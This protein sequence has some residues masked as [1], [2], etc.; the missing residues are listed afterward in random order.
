MNLQCVPIISVGKP[1]IDYR[2]RLISR[3]G[4]LAGRNQTVTKNSIKG[5]EIGPVLAFSNGQ[6]G[7]TRMVAKP[8][9]T[10]KTA[11][12]LMR[13]HFAPRW[14]RDEVIDAIVMCSRDEAHAEKILRLSGK[15]G[16]VPT[17]EDIRHFAFTKEPFVSPDPHCPQCG[18]SGFITRQ[19]R[20]HDGA[21]MCSCLLGGR[22]GLFTA[23]FM[24]NSGGR[25]VG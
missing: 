13:K 9:L 22:K 4:K 12:R 18:G 19:V 25:R 6:E 2:K 16:R 20:G 14:N 23:G 10:R 7:E 1:G 5:A 15:L 8:A 21:E 11:A 24:A 3:L 17:E